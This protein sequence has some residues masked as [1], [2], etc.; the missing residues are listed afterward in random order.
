M[1]KKF[2]SKFCLSA[3]IVMAAVAVT[4]FYSCKREHFV[5]STTSDVNMFSY[6][7]KYPDQFS[8]FQQILDKAGY[9]GFLN[10]Y[11][12][13][14]C[15]APTNDGVKA[16]LKAAGKSSVADI[17]VNTAKNMVKIAL[18]QDTISTQMFTDGK[19]RTA[20][21]YGQYLITGATFV[22]GVASTTVNKQANIVQSNIRVG[23]GIIHAID[24]VLLPASLTLAKM[25]EQNP[26][27]AIFTQALKST[28]FY[29]T[30]N[31]DASANTNINRKYVTLIAQTDS[32]FNAAGIGSYND[33][34][35]KYSTTGNP[36]NPSDSL[37]LFVAY[38]ILPELNY[39]ADIISAQSHITLAPQEVITD[40]L[41]GTTILLNNDTFNGVLEPGVAL[42]RAM[43]DNSATNGVLHS[44]KSN[45][46][47]KVR[48]PSPV[49][50][51]LGDQPEIR[52]LT[53]VFRKA[54]K[55]VQF[56]AGQLADVTW[57]ADVITYTAVASTDANFYY[58]DDLLTFNSLRTA[59]TTMNYIDFKTPTLIKGRYK[60]WVDFR[61][62]AGGSNIQVQFD[63]QPLPNIVNFPDNLPSTTDSG[64]VLESKGYKRYATAQVNGTAP[65]NNKMVGRL[66]GVIDV[67]S[68]DRHHIKF[69]AIGNTKGAVTID[70]VEFR[71]IDMDQEKPTFGRDGT[72]TP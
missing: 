38:R 39:L 58:W 52:K 63:G 5:T 48:K 1:M 71:P 68:T 72:I 28:G 10:A 35:K 51:D 60:V 59:A 34:V 49:Y 36:K 62:S 56:T 3:I 11:G 32:V 40:Q 4:C 19:L 17:D 65:T 2:I 27:Y 25:V 23:N 69:V 54:G 8:M 20:T 42:D 70:M 46:R 24:N 30:L 13:Y 53:S 64:P 12:T 9:S 31:V 44:V 15:F 6:F 18:I 16:Y 7:D 61:S 29:D 66:A 55:S 21:M 57:N 50:F 37:Y 26:K 45:F 22:N 14:T 43:S 41:S 47:I 33:L 67:T